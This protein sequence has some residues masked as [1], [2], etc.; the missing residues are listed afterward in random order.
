VLGPATVITQQ[1]TSQ[2][3]IAG[4]DVSFTV[5]AAGAAPLA[6]QWLKDGVNVVGAT[7]ASLI[8]SNVQVRQIGNYAVVITNAY[9]SV[10]SNLASLTINPE[11]GIARGKLTNFSVRMATTPATPTLTVGFVIGGAGGAS[12]LP[13][14]LRGIGPALTAFGV[15]GALIDPVLT[16]SQGS[17]VLNSNDNWDSTTRVSNVSAALGAFPL[18]PGSLDAA[19]YNSGIAAGSYTAQITGNAGSVGVA[20][21]EIYDAASASVAATGRLINASARGRI[22]T[23]GN[24]LV[25]GLVISGQ[26]P[27][28]MLIRGLG[29]ALT[30]FGVTGVLTD[31]TLRIHNSSAELIAANDDWND[32]SLLGA[33]FL[34][35]SAFSPPAA[36]KDAALLLSLQPGSY[37]VV[38]SGSS[39]GGEGLIEIYEIP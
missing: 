34:R 3:V 4:Q 27:I 20:L 38:L 17:T 14:L 24:V 35:V 2:S 23:G 39:G 26:T 6:Y 25:A 21:A 13:V 1:P 28:Q 36:S 22:D 32:D 19:L 30:R 33:A 10:T 31:P 7:G 16:L 37:T 15:S 29:P 18:N 5:T 8:L 11:S 12:T 9:G